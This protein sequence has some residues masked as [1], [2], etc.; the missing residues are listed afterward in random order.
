MKRRSYAKKRDANEPEIVEALKRVGC[1]V[2]HK[3]E[4]DLHVYFRGREF[5]LEVKNPEAEWRI[6]SKQRRIFNE[7]KGTLIQVVTNPMQALK[8]VGAING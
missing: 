6:T 3:D 7:N 1:E 5:K 2:E 8:A 4:Y